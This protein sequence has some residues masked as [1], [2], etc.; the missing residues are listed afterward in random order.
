[1]RIGIIGT[2]YVGLVTGACFAQTGHHV[3]CVDVDRSKVAML[4]K[5]RVPIY[6]PG[7]AELIAEGRRGKTLHFSA[8]VKAAA[9]AAD[10]IFI[11]VGTPSK[12]S[13]GHA[14]LSNLYSAVAEVGPVLRRGCLIVIKSTVPVGTC[15]QIAGMIESLR[16]DSAFEVASNPE[17]LRA[18]CAIHDFKVPDRVV[19]GAQSESALAILRGLYREMGVDNSRI[20][21]TERRSAELIKYAANGFLATKIAFI[22][23]IADLCENVNARVADVAMGIG[24]DRRIGRQFLD[25]GPGFGGSCFPKD[26]RALA[27]IGEDH[28]TPLRI[29]EAVL[30]SNNLRRQSIAGKVR[31]AGGGDLRGKKVALFG[32]TFKPGTDDMRDAPSITLAQALVDGGA[33][34]HAYDPVGNERAKAL[35]PKSVR[36]H[37]TALGAARGA[38]MAV[39]VTEWDEFHQLDLALLRQ[40][41]AAPVLV[42]LR[43]MFSEERLTRNGF[44]YRGIGNGSASLQGRAMRK[45]G[46]ERVRVG[47]RAYRRRGDTEASGAALARI[48]AAE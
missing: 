1:M 38:D 5:G 32:L 48:E 20:V 43:N 9:A 23:E 17:F 4:N 18:G 39:V 35:L 44:R 19:I 11:A 2:G 26:A 45:P 28:G 24:L 12:E 34:V 33:T 3:T 30:T 41:M 6:E 37:P 29:I 46:G 22:N 7:L 36:Y 10:I 40:Q 27:R 42:D 14:D 25:A 15:D 16:S 13:D 47:R 21:A 8:D 31:A